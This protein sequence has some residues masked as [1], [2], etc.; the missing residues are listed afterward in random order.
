MLEI[1]GLKMR[2]VISECGGDGKWGEFWLGWGYF[3]N[4]VDE[5]VNAVSFCNSA[6]AGSNAGS[7]EMWRVV[8]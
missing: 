4:A 7:C 2:R 3:L 8:G 6:M 1:T 5:W